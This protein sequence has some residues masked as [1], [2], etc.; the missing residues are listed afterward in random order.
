[1]A[2]A[3]MPDSWLE[4]ISIGPGVTWQFARY[5]ALRFTWGSALVRR[6]QTGPLLGPQFGVQIV[7]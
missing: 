2:V 5:G 6:G 3:G 1:M 7:F 4:L